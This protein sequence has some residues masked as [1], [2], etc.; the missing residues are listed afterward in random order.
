MPTT[1]PEALPGRVTALVFF[2]VFLDLV[3]FGLV[4]PLLPFYVE[5]LGG[6]AQTVGAMLACF[7]VAQLAATPLMGR[8]SDRFGRR[9]V[10]LL[11]LLGNALAMLVFAAASHLGLL[12][13]L[14]VSRLLAG[15]TAGN[16]AACQAAVAD[17]TTGE[18]RAAGM[19]RLGAGIGMGL[20]VGPVFSS[21]LSKL[22]SSAPA[23]GAAVLAMSGLGAAALWL[24]ETRQQREG[25]ATAQGGS[26]GQELVRW[27]VLSVVL[28]YFLVFLGISGHQV[29]FSLLTARRFG[30]TEIEVGRSFA[31]LGLVMFLV[32]GVLLG[33]LVRVFRETSLLLAGA[34]MW[35][36]GMALISQTLRVE[37]ML[38]GLVMTSA[39]FGLV[40]PLLSSIASR[41]ASEE[42]RGVVLGIAQSA[43]G[44]A[45]AVGPLAGG[46]LFEHVSIGGPHL[47]G[48]CAGLVCLLLGLDMRR[49]ER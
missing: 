16:L 2:I 29:A 6:T 15:A 9:P 47:L 36:A 31:L 44:L 18:Q 27:S 45:R 21:E 46:A 39:G 32:Q 41:R 28:T 10:I 38:G 25:P 22:S 11:S 4:I 20:V 8:L 40:N 37:A 5:K 49:S 48:A 3:G 19:G 24:P 13:L 33:R 43:G 14:F 26:V 35:S 30:W 7:S 34:L 23:L 12:W 17:V 1:H 42:H